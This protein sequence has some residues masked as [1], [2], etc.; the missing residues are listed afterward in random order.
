MENAVLIKKKRLCVDYFSLH[1]SLLCLYRNRYI[2]IPSFNP[3]LPFIPEFVIRLNTEMSI[4]ILQQPVP[5]LAAWGDRVHPGER[6]LALVL[7]L[8]GIKECLETSAKRFNE[9]AC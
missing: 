6:G 8:S 9:G 4:S 5:I 1:S 2:V 3:R 7:V